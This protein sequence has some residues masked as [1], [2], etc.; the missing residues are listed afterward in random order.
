[1]YIKIV[2]CFDPFSYFPP[3]E[4]TVY[5][6]CAR[7]PVTLLRVTPT[8]HLTERNQGRRNIQSK[9]RTVKTSG[10]NK[11]MHKKISFLSR[12]F[13]EL[14]YSYLFIPIQEDRLLERSIMARLLGLLSSDRFAR[15]ISAVTRVIVILKQ[16]AT[17]CLQILV[18]A[19]LQRFC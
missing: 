11:Y 9:T 16:T 12:F 18:C 7:L 19:F 14:K 6:H 1:M 10:I 2:N 13:E 15:E 5:L 17:F 3:L 4:N 8:L